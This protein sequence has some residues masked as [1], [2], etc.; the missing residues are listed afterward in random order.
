MPAESQCL[1]RQGAG[2][3][4]GAAQ[5]GGG[6]LNKTLEELS[7]L[8]GRSSLRIMKA[9]CI[10]LSP[11]MNMSWILLKRSQLFTA[12]SPGLAK[13]KEADLRKEFQGQEAVLLKTIGKLKTELQMVQDEA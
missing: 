6:G 7:G 4:G 3:S 10:K 8:S 1:S 12:E 2:E 13:E 11:F 9:S 5:D